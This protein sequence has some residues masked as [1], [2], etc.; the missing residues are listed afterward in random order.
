MR[1][2]TE[3]KKIGLAMNTVSFVRHHTEH[4][5]DVIVKIRE[6]YVLGVLQDDNVEYEKYRNTI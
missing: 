4:I 5:Q 3:F 1:Q 2:E 6:A